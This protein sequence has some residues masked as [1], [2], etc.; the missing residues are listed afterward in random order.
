MDNKY[1]TGVRFPLQKNAVFHWKSKTIEIEYRVLYSVVLLFLVNI[2]LPF[3]LFAAVTDTQR[4]AIASDVAAGVDTLSILQ[5]AVADGMPI[6]MAVQAVIAAGTDP[7][8]VVYVACP[9]FSSEAVIRG[10]EAAVSAMGL[11]EAD[12]LTQITAIVSV[13]LQAGSSES[14]ISDAL[15]NSG[16]S[17]TVIANTLTGAAQSPSP[18]LGYSAPEP[19]SPPPTASVIGGGGGG[20]GAPIGGSQYGAPPTQPASK[21]KP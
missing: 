6:E 13:A 12:Y 19:A 15:S 21:S 5:K 10:A 7:G 18:V 2:L 9:V 8:R 17:P 3:P 11:S 20:G 4:A 1:A 16:V 14:Q